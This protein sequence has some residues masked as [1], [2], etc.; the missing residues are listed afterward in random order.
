MMT[1]F[2]VET[3]L[4]CVVPSVGFKAVMVKLFDAVIAVLNTPSAVEAL[5]PSLV[6]KITSAAAMLVLAIVTV[7]ATSVAEPIKSV[8]A[9]PSMRICFPA[10]CRRR[11]PAVEIRSVPA[12]TVVPPASVVVVVSDP[13]AV[14]AAGKENVIVEPEPVEVSWLAVPKI[15]MLPS[16]GDNAPPDPPVTVTTPP[17]APEPAAIQEAEPDVLAPKNQREGVDLLTHT[18]LKT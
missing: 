6:T 15:F 12:V 11:F 4:V 18:W 9:P 16:V 17:V 7:P 8:A 14:I 10:P 1:Y 2:T 13:G 5:M 3:S